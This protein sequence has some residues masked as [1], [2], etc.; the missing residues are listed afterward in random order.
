LS[1]KKLEKSVSSEE[2]NSLVTDVLPNLV[3]EL[4]K[5]NYNFERALDYYAVETYGKVPRTGKGDR[6]SNS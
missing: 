1:T 6:E 3:K 2:F 4:S 5:F